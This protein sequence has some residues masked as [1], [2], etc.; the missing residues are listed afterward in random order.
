MTKRLAIWLPINWLCLLAAFWLNYP[1]LPLPESLMAPHWQPLS[2]VALVLSTI[3]S[4]WAIMQTVADFRERISDYAQRVHTS[5]LEIERLQ[6][7]QKRAVLTREK[8]ER[9]SQNRAE[10]SE[11]IADDL[12][13]LASDAIRTISPQ[14]QMSHKA[15]SQI[16]QYADELA[17]VAQLERQQQLPEL[18]DV[19]LDRLFATAAE[20]HPI[21]LLLADSDIAVS[22][23]K[24]WGDQLVKA[25]V[26]ATLAFSHEQEIQVIRHQHSDLNEVVRMTISGPLNI[27]A[28]ELRR[29]LRHASLAK[30]NDE[31]LGWQLAIAA[32]YAERLG[33]IVS[34]EPEGLV[35]ILP[36]RPNQVTQMDH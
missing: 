6:H 22:M 21:N 23:P 2:W 7:E 20:Q 17:A 27:S 1:D 14:N 24:A 25:M 15:V 18:D 11:W 5:H 19:W 8:A 26:H 33:G 13:T 9:F 12:Q 31:A 16:R 28:S 34:H 36:L 29:A 32:R 3:A 30:Q 35:I 4:V 10:L